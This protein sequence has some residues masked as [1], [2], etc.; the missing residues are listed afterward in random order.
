MQA[1]M[2]QYSFKVLE[3]PSGLPPIRQQSDKICLI[4]SN[5]PSNIRWYRYL[6][7]HKHEIQNQLK[8]LL[9]AVFIQPNV[10][11][12]FNSTTIVHEEGQVLEVV[13]GH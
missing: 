2:N 6:Y 1:I 4:P 13:H 7:Q 3:E 5:L 9:D 8:E 11:F 10:N 12:F